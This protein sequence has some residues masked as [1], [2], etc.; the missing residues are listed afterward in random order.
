MASKAKQRWNIGNSETV[1]KGIWLQP[2]VPFIW[3]SKPDVTENV[4]VR[5]LGNTAEEHCGDGLLLIRKVRAEQRGSK[6]AE[7]KAE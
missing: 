4:R 1:L 3:S 5:I 6:L 2:V 7:S